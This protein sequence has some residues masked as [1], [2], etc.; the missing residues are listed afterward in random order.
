MKV[1]IKLLGIMAL[2]SYTQ[3]SLANN[4]AFTLKK[5]S[6][7]TYSIASIQQINTESICGSNNLQEIELYSGGHANIGFSTNLISYLNRPVGVIKRKNNV[8]GAGYC[9]GTL[10]SNNTFLTASHCVDNT[11]VG[12]FIA[13]DFQ[14]NAVS[15]V[16]RIQR[17][18]RIQAVLEDGVNANLDYAILALEGAPGNA[19]NWEGRPFGWRSAANF[20]NARIAIIQHP[21]GG[22]KKIDAGNTAS[23]AS[24]TIRYSNVDT[25]PG[26]SGSGIID[27]YGVLVGVHTNG[28]CTASGGQNSGVSMNAILNSSNILHAGTRS[29]IDFFIDGNKIELYPEESSAYF[30]SHNLDSDTQLAINWGNAEQR[31]TQ[32]EYKIDFGSSVGLNDVN[33][34]S[35]N[36]YPGGTNSGVLNY[37]IGGISKSI[38]PFHPCGST[39]S[40]YNPNREIRLFLRLRH[41]NSNSPSEWRYTRAI[42]INY[43]P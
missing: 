19:T 17:T 26:S 25:E 29:V 11:I 10:I 12:D 41:L 7:S 33:W 38:S 18:Y 39:S 14:L 32:I 42:C 20:N 43:Q 37:L 16:P 31:Q 40:F 13:L 36:N 30:T 15:N 28:G 6:P 3:I 34:T 22:F 21:N 5:S 27:N 23:L 8:G 35:Y 24:N 2:V 9:S 4:P 1:F